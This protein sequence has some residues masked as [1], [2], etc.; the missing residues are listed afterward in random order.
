MTEVV[1]NLISNA[2]KYSPPGS[3]ITVCSSVSGQRIKMAVSDQGP[4]LNDQ[5]KE[6]LFQMF[7]TLGSVPTGGEKSTG[8][9]LAIAKKI[10][11]THG[12]EIGV[13]SEPGQGCTFWFSLPVQ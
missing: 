6:R 10:I 7:T 1:D 13:D 2:I 8:L 11:D 3:E 5:Q 9:G 12:G 4:G